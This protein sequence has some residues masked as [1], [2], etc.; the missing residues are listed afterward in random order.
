MGPAGD[1][2][3]GHRRVVHHRVLQAFA[4]GCWLTAAGISGSR[5]QYAPDTS[6]RSRINRFPAA[7][8][9]GRTARPAE[10]HWSSTDSDVLSDEGRAYAEKLRAAGVPLTYLHYPR[11]IHDS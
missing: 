1:V 6:V 9:R 10:G 8:R 5:D 7:R 3:P 11:M 2:L 4:T